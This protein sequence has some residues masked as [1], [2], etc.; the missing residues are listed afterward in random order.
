MQEIFPLRSQQL[1]APAQ[2]CNYKIRKYKINTYSI[3][4]KKR[5]INM[6]NQYT[7]IKM[8]NIYK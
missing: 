5:K 6:E 7:Q 4:D 1:Y 3:N 8:L 2:N